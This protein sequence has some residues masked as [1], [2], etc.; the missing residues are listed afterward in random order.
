MSWEFYT[1]IKIRS[2][3]CL[4]PFFDPQIRHLPC[5]LTNLPM[6]LEIRADLGT[7]VKPHMIG[8]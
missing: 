3:F 4:A 5:H 7:V 2:Y 8:S 1:S 6:I